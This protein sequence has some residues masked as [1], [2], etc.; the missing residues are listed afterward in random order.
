MKKKGKLIVI[1]GGDGAGK[2]T[3]AKL[4]IDALKQ[5]SVSVEYLDFPRYDESLFGALT[6]RALKGEF[7]DFRHLSPYLAS[8]PYSL[9]RVAA[10]DAIKAALGKGIVICNRYTSSNVAFQA[11]KLSGKARRDFIDFLE[12]AEYDELGLPRPSLVIYLYVPAHIAHELVAGKERRGYLNKKKGARDQH[13]SDHRYQGMVVDTYLHLCR[14]RLD[15]KAI[16]CA[17]KGK[18]LS[19]EEIHARVMKEVSAHL[20]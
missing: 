1:E 10:K 8:L 9:D 6:G 11:T 13:E 4:L 3:Q 19:R 16:V 14:R 7:G 2:A 12:R 15:W 20:R 5:K 17:R 18:L